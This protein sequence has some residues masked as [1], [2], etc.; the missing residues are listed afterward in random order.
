[1]LST[2]WRIELTFQVAMRIRGLRRADPNKTRA[3][4]VYQ[5]A[6]GYALGAVYMLEDGQRGP[7]D[8]VDTKHSVELG[9]AWAG[10]S[11]AQADN[12]R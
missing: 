10:P 4:R 11:T 8:V 5:P 3:L 1:M 12:R 6:Q 7:F 2:R 9:S